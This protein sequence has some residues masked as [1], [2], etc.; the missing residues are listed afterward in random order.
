[1]SD[2]RSRRATIDRARRS[3]ATKT[4][5]SPAH[6]P[7]C[8]RRCSVPRGSSDRRPHP[9]STRR[10][11]RRRRSSISK[12]RVDPTGCRLVLSGSAIASDRSRSHS[13]QSLQSS[14]DWSV[15]EFD[16]V[17]YYVWYGSVALLSSSSLSIPYFLIHV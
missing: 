2:R 8:H 7:R 14:V 11:A 9:C 4:S 15:S 6:S 5:T 17:S 10:I 16:H 3:N 1:M 12:T 13:A